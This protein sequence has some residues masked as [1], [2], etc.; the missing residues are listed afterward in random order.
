MWAKDH[1]CS[2]NC[3]LAKNEPQPILAKKRAKTTSS[4]KEIQD[5]IIKRNTKIFPTS[6]KINSEHYNC[7]TITW[8]KPKKGGEIS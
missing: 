7:K 1:G 5:E 8:K 6:S 4:G 3:N 2:K